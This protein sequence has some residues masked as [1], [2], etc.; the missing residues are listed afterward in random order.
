MKEPTV[1]HGIE[2]AADSALCCGQCG[3][4]FGKSD[5]L[6]NLDFCSVKCETEWAEANG[7]HVVKV[8]GHFPRIGYLDGDGFTFPLN[9]IGLLKELKPDC[10]DVFTFLWHPDRPGIAYDYPHEIENMAVVPVSTFEHWW[11]AQIDAKTRNMVRKAEK[12][13]VETAESVLDD[14]LL[15]GIHEMYNETP[16]RQG[17]QFSHY[18]M[19][20]DVVKERSST[21]PRRSIY[22]IAQSKGRIIGFLRMILSESQTFACIVSILALIRERDK[23]PMNALISRA[24]KVAAERGISQL[25]YGQFTYGQK[26]RDT[27]LD[28]KLSNGFERLDV[29]R[30]YVPLNLRGEIALRLGLHHGVRE[31]IPESI[32]APLRSIRAKWLEDK[33]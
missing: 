33:C 2:Y 27:L 22:L 31:R 9:P 15:R 21:F 24:V 8:R 4:R 3:R 17:R 10:M 12:K 30:Y 18:G 13:G 1:I 28:F 32:L 25:C 23:A 29:P 26:G 7:E 11:T 16:V 6:R 19:T 20:L 5:S 14:E